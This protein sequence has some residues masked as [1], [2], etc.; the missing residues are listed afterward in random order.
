M[1][2]VKG[3][4]AA[5]GDY[6]TQLHVKAEVIARALSSGQYDFGFLHV[7]AVDDAGHDRQPVMKASPPAIIQPPSLSSLCST[8]MADQSEFHLLHG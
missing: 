8:Y 6:G 1:P 5:A 4:L 2:V 3:S 7:K